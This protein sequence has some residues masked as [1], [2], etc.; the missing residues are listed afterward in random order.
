MG[1]TI[2]MKVNLPKSRVFRVWKGQ[3]SGG[4]VRPDQGTAPIARM[5]GELDCLI[6]AQ[7]LSLKLPL[8][9]NN[10]SEFERIPKLTLE[11][12]AEPR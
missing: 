9:T 4:N 2:S 3:R 1:F 11:I 12:W 10:P 6:A 7:A 5:I 8:V